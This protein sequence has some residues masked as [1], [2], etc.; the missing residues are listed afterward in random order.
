MSLGSFS[1]LIGYEKIT[2]S[3]NSVGKNL[4]DTTRGVDSVFVHCD[5]IKRMSNNVPSD[6]I[7]S[8]S[9]SN[10]L[11]SYPF[12]IKEQLL[13]WHPVKNNFIDSVNIRVTDGKG[14]ILGFNG[15]D[16]MVKIMIGKE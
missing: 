16:I 4:P 12:E 15:I 14:G 10:L 5:L 3:G 1:D 11:V 6:V 9:T 13:E 8:F 7:Y 2:L